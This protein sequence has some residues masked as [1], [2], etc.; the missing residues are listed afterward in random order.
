MGDKGFWAA[1][2]FDAELAGFEGHVEDGL[3][4]NRESLSDGGAAFFG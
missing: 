3:V 4:G 1:P 2:F